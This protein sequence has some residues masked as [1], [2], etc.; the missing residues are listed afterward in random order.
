MIRVES[1]LPAARDKLV[2]IADDRQLTEAA[3]LLASVNRHMVVVCDGSGRMVG[4][5]TRTDIVRQIQHCE[6]CACTTKC[7]AVMSTPVVA[8]QPGDWLPD[9]WAT[10]KQKGL[11]NIPVVDAEARPLGLLSA[12]DALERLLLEA[13]HEEELLKDYVMCVGYR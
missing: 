10:M 1:I 8:C 9:V 7:I 12:R 13:E 11:Q 6:G 5:V 4:V 3:S 2:L